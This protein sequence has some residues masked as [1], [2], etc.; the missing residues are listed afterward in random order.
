M[1]ESG[2]VRRILWG[3][4]LGD[5][6]D[7]SRVPLSAVFRLDSGSAVL[8]VQRRHCESAPATP[9]RS[10]A[11]P[12]VLQVAS[13]A[14]HQRTVSDVLAEKADLPESDKPASSSTCGWPAGHRSRSQPRSRA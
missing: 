10:V 3:T 14:A 11:L 12:C 4:D 1:A 8:Q 6:A 13:D 9:R 2:V 7:F 5:L